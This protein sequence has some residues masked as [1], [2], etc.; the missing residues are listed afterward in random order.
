MKYICLVYHEENKLDA[1][2]QAELD[3]LVGECRAWVLELETGGHHVCSA[4]LQSVRTATTVRNRNGQLSVTDGPFAE[5]KE[6]LGGFTILNARD[7]NEA[8]QLASKLPAVRLGS[9]EVR[10][11]L[12]PD[13][14][15]TDSV[16][17]KIGAAILSKSHP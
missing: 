9:V 14:E 11:V 3:A 17:Q 12:E 2:S 8:I 13:V 1:L 16:D 10:P 5:T 4:G 7:L 6:F 15:L